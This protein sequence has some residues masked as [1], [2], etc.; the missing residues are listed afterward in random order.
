M[1]SLER[2]QLTLQHRQADRIPVYPLINSVSRKTL[3]ISYE[4]WTRD[5]AA[6]AEA[7]LRT[8]DLLDLDIV[9]SLVDLSVE[10]A[11]WG[12]EMLYF[13]DRAACPNDA[14]RLIKG[15]DGYRRIGPLDPR[16]TPRMSGHI[17]LCRRLVEAKGDQK[18]VVAFV[19]A[20]LGVA[21]MLRGQAEFFMDMIT[22]PEEVKACV[23][24][25][26]DTLKDYCTALAGTGVH[27][28]MLDT[29]YASRSIMSEAMWDAFE[30]PFVE[31]LAEHI[32][33]LGLMVM[34]HNCGHGSYLRRQMERMRPQAVSFLHVPSDCASY[35]EMARKYGGKVTLIGHLDPGWLVGATDPEIEEECRV[36]IERYRDGGGFILSTGCEYP[37]VLGL[38]KARVIV[39]AAKR[40]G[41]YR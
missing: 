18:P 13:E 21:S 26:S 20:P 3:G 27:A 38:D 8:T 37:S 34:V 5:E 14:N 36:Q 15:V 41:R 16:R 4:T 23:R 19:F 7:I 1:N 33:S 24:V 9:C 22:H 32:R 39:E 12:Q 31:E 28:V 2:V 10:A 25:I 35:D 30:G 6:C 11:D 40:Y 17:G 29:L